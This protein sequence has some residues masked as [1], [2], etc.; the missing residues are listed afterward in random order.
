MHVCTHIRMYK[1]H[2]RL[3]DARSAATK[4]PQGM[5]EKDKVKWI[6]AHTDR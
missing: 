6:P 5:L 1:A 4:W 3:V 2:L